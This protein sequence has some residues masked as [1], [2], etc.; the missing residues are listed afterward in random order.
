MHAIRKKWLFLLSVACVV[1]LVAL[2]GPS[3]VAIILFGLIVACAASIIRV[4]W[5]T[6]IG[7]EDPLGSARKDS[8]KEAQK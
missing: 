6:L 5:R 3:V 8:R 7:E 1:A 2:F 4:L